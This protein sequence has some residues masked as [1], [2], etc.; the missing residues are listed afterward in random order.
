MIL[1]DLAMYD[2]SFM[3]V[4]D[5]WYDY[6]LSANAQSE[7][8]TDDLKIRKRAYSSI[9]FA[10]MGGSAT[11]GDIACSVLKMSSRVVRGSTLPESVDKNSL[12][13]ASSVSGNTYET[14][15]IVRE[16]VRK[17][18]DTIVLS[19]GGALETL[20][21]KEGLSHINIQNLGAPRLSL[22]CLVYPVMNILRVFEYGM[23]EQIASSLETLRSL[24]H[25]ARSSSPTSVNIAKKIALFIG[26]TLPIC[27]YNSDLRAA[28]IRFRNSLNENAKTH[29]ISED[30]EEACHNSIVPFSDKQSSECSVVLLRSQKERNSVSS[31]FRIVKNFL[32]TK[33]IPVLELKGEGNT[34]L[35]SIMGLV[36]LLDYSTVYLSLLNGH[37]PNA[38]AAIDYVK[39]AIK[40]QLQTDFGDKSD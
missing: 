34:L 16:C 13:I 18:I 20:A 25:S 4:Y 10:G 17:K 8:I 19:A 22:P 28:G 29:A 39:S 7:N 36:Y 32:E 24:S 9:V 15:E 1:D 12:V 35:A 3:K 38:T 14:I 33:G 2:S 23:E 11:V 6:S 31:R 27:Y 21:K 5:N 37:D 26:C 30:V 40:E